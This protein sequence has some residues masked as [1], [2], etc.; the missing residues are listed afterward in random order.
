MDSSVEAVDSDIVI[1][2]KKFLVEEGENDNIVDGPQNFIYAFADTVGEGYGP[3]RGKAVINLSS[4]GT[5]NISDP[6]EGKWLANCILAGL[7]WRLLTLLA[8]GADLLQDFFPPGPTWFKI[9]E[10]CNIINCFFTT[11]SSYSDRTD[12][13]SGHCM[14]LIQ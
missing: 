9:H 4:G 8:V 3:K 2:L 13:K 12:R 14:V 11:I 6:N 7:A 10:Y 5:S 1:K